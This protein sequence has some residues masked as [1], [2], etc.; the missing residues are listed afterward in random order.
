M[1]ARPQGGQSLVELALLMTILL[2]L[3]FGLVDFGRV[4]YIHV[5]L[6]NASREGARYAAGASP[7]CG[8]ASFT[9]IRAKVKA[10]QP[11]L[12]LT[13]DMISVDCSQ[14]DRRTVRVTYRFRPITPMIAGALDNPDGSGTIP[15]RTWATLPVTA[16]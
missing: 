13:D 10:E 6:T 11:G 8:E 12:G 16:R 4:F 5:G 3:C 7:A 15:L 2:W 9:A 1:G 14:E